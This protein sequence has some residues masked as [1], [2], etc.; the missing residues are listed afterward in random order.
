MDLKNRSW[1]VLILEITIDNKKEIEQIEKLLLIER[2]RL[3]FR[4]SFAIL[5]KYW[6][7][8]FPSA[9]GIIMSL[10]TVHLGITDFTFR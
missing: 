9:G 2:E 7:S 8:D 3:R 10:L 4:P 5:E 1:F 6:S